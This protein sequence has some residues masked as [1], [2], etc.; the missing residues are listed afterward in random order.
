MQTDLR[1]GDVMTVGVITLPADRSV[2][3]AAKLLRKTKVGCVI[4][5]NK[6]KA[7][8]IV[9]ERDIAYK[10]VAD[11]KDARKSTLREVM[12]TPLRVISA[13]EKIEDAA[14]A[15]KENKVKRLPVI[16]K[17]ERLVGIITEGDLLRAFPGLIE[18]LGESQQLRFPK[19]EVFAG[20]CEK[21]GMY[22]EDLVRDQGKLRCED[23]REEEEV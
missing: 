7:D 21:C 18:V 9:T 10:V 5:T 17:K 16:D 12:S 19:N 13:S 3:E 23:C 14:L 4:V 22:S 2:E 20:V 8:G 1:V 15:L 11:G 6:G